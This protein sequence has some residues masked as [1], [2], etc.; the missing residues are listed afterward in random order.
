MT[1]HNDLVVG[2][3]IFYRPKVLMEVVEVKVLGPNKWVNL[4][5]VEY[6]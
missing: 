2:D 1:S 4:I 3:I 6:F 5:E